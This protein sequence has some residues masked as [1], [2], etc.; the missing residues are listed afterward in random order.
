MPQSHRRVW[1]YAAFFVKE[2]GAV[3]RLVC[4]L[5]SPG[6]EHADRRG[7]HNASREPSKNDEPLR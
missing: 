6:R 3:Y 5:T 4:N 2:G 7:P 1:A